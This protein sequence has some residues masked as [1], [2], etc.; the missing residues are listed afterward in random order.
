MDKDQLAALD[1]AVREAKAAISGS[2]TRPQIDKLERAKH[3]FT[4]ALVN[5]YR[6]GQLVLIG[7]DA[8]ETMKTALL[9]A[10]FSDGEHMVEEQGNC[11][12]EM[13]ADYLAGVALAALGV[14]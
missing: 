2:Y 3:E 14:K 8:V 9:V 5:A 11:S 7:P 10:R 1:R 13:I 12:A 6:T 4:T